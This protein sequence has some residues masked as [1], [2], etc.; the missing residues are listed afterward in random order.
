MVVRHHAARAGRVCAENGRAYGVFVSD[1]AGG[2]CHG[3]GAA[4]AGVA[5]LDRQAGGQSV[6]A[7]GGDSSLRGTVRHRAQRLQFAVRLDDGG[8]DD[9]C[10][11][12]DEI[13]GLAGKGGGVACA[14]DVPGVPYPFA[15]AG[16]GVSEGER[17]WTDWPGGA[18]AGRVDFDGAGGVCDWCGAG[19]AEASGSAAHEESAMNKPIYLY[20]T[21][22]FPSPESWRGGYCLDAAKAL[23]RDGRYDVRVM[24]TG[25]G[26]DY[27]WDGIKVYRFKKLGL[28]CGVAPFLVNWL[29]NRRFKRKLREMGIRPEEVAVCHANT[30]G[31]THYAAYFKGFNPKAKTV[32][33]MHSSYSFGLRS[34]RLGVLPGHATILYLYLRRM[35]A[36]VDLLAFVS[37]M[38]RRTFG[39]M[40]VG[41][42]EGEVR[43]VRSQLW[44]G[45]WLPA[46]KI[47]ETAVVYNGL[48]TALFNAEGRKPHEGFVIG[49]VANF[50]P[51]KD[52]MTLLKTVNLLKGKIP[53][54]KV[55]LVGT[56]EMLGACKEYVRQQGLEGIV[57]FEPEIDHRAMPDFYRGLD[58]FVMPSRL[59]GFLCVCVESWACGAP[60]M[61]CEGT[62][63]PE[64]VPEEEK[65]MWLFRP[66]DAQDLAD[67]VLAYRANPKEQHFTRSLEIGHIWR[68]FLI[69]F[70]AG[71]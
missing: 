61:F 21:P 33:Q 52:Q 14:I 23:M 60:A 12:A 41:A 35:C 36:K 58:L 66:M 45:R 38:A 18:G 30:L 59:E 31:F 53:E 3:A 51:L 56:G 48:D 39:K 6:D 20:I 43:D 16:V 7:R 71:I 68:E 10:V 13:A 5:G 11:R 64:L 9:A 26:G 57:S 32:V 49:C 65:G 44:L 63:L 47:N 4:R 69:D 40:Y 22:F 15:R 27:E 17:G 67:K 55:R 24:V 42:P 54:L 50:Q 70:R 19:F 29:N 25:K 2:V 34:G 28:P 62:A 8:A 1:F 37:D 46:L